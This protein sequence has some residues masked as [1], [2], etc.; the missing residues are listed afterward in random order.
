M[1][2]TWNCSLSHRRR[3]FLQELGLELTQY[4]P[5]PIALHI[6]CSV[7]KKQKR[8]RFVSCPR[9]SD[10][11]ARLCCNSC[12]AN[13][14]QDHI[15]CKNCAIWLFDIN[16][17]THIVSFFF[18]VYLLLKINDPTYHWHSFS[19]EN[20]GGVHCGPHAVKLWVLFCR[21]G[22]LINI[23]IYDQSGFYK[24]LRLLETPPAFDWFVLKRS[25]CVCVWRGIF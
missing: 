4:Q 22:G 11:K 6:P 20:I 12:E 10:K 14:C 17:I 18:A 9:S 5:L 21:I 13:V 24:L 3:I 7:G 19:K 23:Y 16:I 2:S 8:G 25:V 15:Y 1:N